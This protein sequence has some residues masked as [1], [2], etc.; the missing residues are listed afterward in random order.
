MLAITAYFIGFNFSMINNLSIRFAYNIE[1]NF[2][3]LNTYFIDFQYD[4]HAHLAVFHFKPYSL[5]YL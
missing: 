3:I 2:K 1:E 5:K 4:I